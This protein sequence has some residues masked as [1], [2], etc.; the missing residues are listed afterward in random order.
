M[1]QAAAQTFFHRY[2]NMV[3]LPA[4]EKYVDSIESF[5]DY[6]GETTSFIHTLLEGDMINP[7]FQV[8]LI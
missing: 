6:I 3:Q 4:Q 7:P 5:C 1:M 2:S 8:K